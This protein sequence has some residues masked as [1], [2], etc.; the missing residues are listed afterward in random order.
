MTLH[1]LLAGS[2]I[3]LALLTLIQLAPIQIN[4]WGWLLRLL[5]KALTCAG[6]HINAGV[7]EQLKELR[8]CQAEMRQKLDGHIEADGRRAAGEVRSQILRFNNE[9]LRGI[10][11]TKEEYIDILS[12]IDAYENYCEANPDYPNNRAILAIETIKEN[13][14]E[15][16]QKRDF[17]ESFG[18]DHNA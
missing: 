2:G 18:G 13:Y 15:R 14:K 4:P 5:R 8:E 16:L 7:L 12:D 10:R 17:L 11:H 6:A 9:L 1:E 3:L